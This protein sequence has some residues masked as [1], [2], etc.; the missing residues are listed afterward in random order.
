MYMSKP[1]KDENKN[2]PI[3]TGFYQKRFFDFLVK[4]RHGLT[5]SLDHASS[6]KLSWIR[7]QCDLCTWR[8]EFSPK[9]GADLQAFLSLK[10]VSVDRAY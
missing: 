10:I 9:A 3:Y 2:A 4:K 6:L 1:T 5:W 8:V 7:L